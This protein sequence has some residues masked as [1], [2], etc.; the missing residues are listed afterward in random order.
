VFGAADPR[1]VY[2][3]DG[4]ILHKVQVLEPSPTL[5]V[6]RTSRAAFGT[7]Q[8]LVPALHFD[9]DLSGL[10]PRGRFPHL[11]R[12]LQIQESGDELSESHHSVGMRPASRLGGAG[13]EVEA[14]ESA[15]MARAISR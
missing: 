6:Q 10:R 4:S 14:R 15:G 13:S 5:V 11:P 1:P 2:A 9:H 8:A 12:R 3:D 7:D